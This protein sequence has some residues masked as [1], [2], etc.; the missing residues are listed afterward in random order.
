[1]KIYKLFFYLFSVLALAGCSVKASSPTE[2]PTGIT[3]VIPTLLPTPTVTPLASSTS[4]ETVM[5]KPTLTAL[6]A[7]STL[8]PSPSAQATTTHIPEIEEKTIPVCPGE[9]KAVSPPD[10][11]GIDGTLVY[12]IIHKQGLFTLGGN[13][14]SKGKLPVGTD[15]EV[16][17]FGFSPDGNWLAY[18]PVV[19]IDRFKKEEFEHSLFVLLS[20]K[21]EKIEHN[22][23]ISKFSTDAVS[24]M[25]LTGF[26]YPRYWINNQLI[27]VTILQESASPDTSQIVF[28]LVKILDPY[29]GIWREDILAGIPSFY[30]INMAGFSPD[31]QRVLYEYPSKGSRTKLVLWD[32]INHKVIWSDPEFPIPYGAIIAWAP[33]NSVAAYTNYSAPWE[34][35]RRVFLIGHDGG[36]RRPITSFDYPMA[37]FEFQ[38]MKW[39]NDSRYLALFGTPATEEVQGQTTLFIYDREINQYIIRCPIFGFAYMSDA[40]WSPDNHYIAYAYWHTPLDIYDMHTGQVIRLV[41]EAETVGWSD[42]FPVNWP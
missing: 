8:I 23:D 26:S 11:F 29:K 15:Q 19:E 17:M 2:I 38:T 36:Q 25:V 40:F 35:D 7:T 6:P 41:K 1:M 34:Q 27:Y 4:T 28:P 16:A 30:P 9:G 5:P 31:M 14:L 42:N 39:S 22:L 24:G 32:L 33:D 21:G 37:G 3:E 13:P 12:Q 10:S 18:A 20:S